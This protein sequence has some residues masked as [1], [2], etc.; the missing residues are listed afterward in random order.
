MVKIGMHRRHPWHLGLVAL[1]AACIAHPGLAAAQ[2]AAPAPAITTPAPATASNYNLGLPMFAAGSADPYNLSA[3]TDTTATPP[4]A[5]ASATATL[6]DSYT[7][8]TFRQN[9]HGYV[10]AGI[11]THNG[12]NLSGGVTMPLVPGKVDLAFGADTGQVGGFQPVTPGGKHKILTY[13]DYYAGVHLH[14]ADNI[15]AYIT[16]SRTHLNLPYGAV[17]PVVP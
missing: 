12:N 15:D 16:V 5:A 7:F 11:A 1:G 2:T 17:V 4:S 14:P 6:P 13:N 10:S 8:D 9:I 3:T